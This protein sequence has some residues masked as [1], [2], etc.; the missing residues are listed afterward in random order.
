MKPI[1]LKLLALICYLIAMLWLVSFRFAVL[2]DLK[3]IVLVLFGTL[4]LTAAAY[5]KQRAS[6][7]QPWDW[8]S[9]ARF[10]AQMT[11][12]LTTFILIFS[13]LS[14]IEATGLLFPEIALSLRPLLYGLIL[15]ILIGHGEEPTDAPLSQAVASPI[16]TAP[17]PEHFIVFLRSKALTDREVQ[18]T[19]DLL[20]GLANKEIAEKWFISESTV[21]KHTHNL[22]KKLD[23]SGR[24]ALRLLYARQLEL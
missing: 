21:K 23:L 24:E 5:P 9:P 19:L 7:G 2:F 6:A 15:Q 18:I 8:R 10:N 3:T 1:L 22:Y 4:L 11:G 13:R 17:D 12:Y 14:D 20:E 16:A